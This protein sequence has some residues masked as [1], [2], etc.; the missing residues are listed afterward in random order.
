[1]RGR[2]GSGGE[3]FRESPSALRDEVGSTP[4]PH[5]VWPILGVQKCH[6]NHSLL[7]STYCAQPRTQH[8]TYANARPKCSRNAHVY[9]YT[10]SVPPPLRASRRTQ[11]TL[12]VELLCLHMLI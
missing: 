6:A 12:Q 5:R 3:S 4:Q 10:A 9:G 1:M 8:A 2:S 11:W 7:G